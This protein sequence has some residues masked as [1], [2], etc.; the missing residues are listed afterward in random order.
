MAD[1]FTR[2]KLNPILEPGYNGWWKIY[3]P[4][5]A[6]DEN[7]KVHLFP[8]VVGADLQSKIAHARATIDN[9]HFLLDY[10]PALAPIGPFETRGLEDPRV[11]RIGNQYHMAFAAYDG[12]DVDLLTATSSSLNGPWE[13]KGP[14]VPDFR[15]T[16]SGGVV[17]RWNGKT[18]YEVTSPKGRDHRSKSGALFPST[19]GG[20]F[21][22]L[23][24]EFRMWLAT[25]DDGYHFDV[26][27]RPFLE[28]RKGSRYF[29]SAF[30][31]M[32]PPPLETDQGWLV[33]YHGV[34]ERFRYQLGFLLL[35]R[36]DPTR[37]LYRSAEP[38]FGPREKYEIDPGPIDVFPG[39]VEAARSR[40]PEGLADFYHQAAQKGVVPQV[41]FCSG[42]LLIDDDIRLYYGAADS[43]V[44]TAVAPL[45]DIL[46]GME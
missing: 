6:I 39:A 34:D 26:I 40:T 10:Q 41:V 38:I 30:V 43:M 31:E 21:F 3:N 32:G 4:A 23:F 46:R 11:T 42:A 36:N 24:G 28:P 17:V 16:A 18:P 27:K 19:I 22:L 33:F 35:D 5:A 7:A 20:R 37:I 13:R 8:R 29:D 15:F 1:I 45:R 12:T 44:C 2:S 25:S 9:E 14:A